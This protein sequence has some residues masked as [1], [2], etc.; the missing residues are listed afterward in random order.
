MNTTMAQSASALS[1]L[2]NRVAAT[3]RARERTGK[4]AHPHFGQ[5][6]S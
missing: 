4:R 6:R 1:P 2:D 5:R 3:I